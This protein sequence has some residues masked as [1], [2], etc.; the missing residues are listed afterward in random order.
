[1]GMNTESRISPPHPAGS[2]ASACIVKR[3]GGSGPSGFP[4]PFSVLILGIQP[5]DFACPACYDP[6]GFCT[7]GLCTIN[8]GASYLPWG[9]FQHSSISPPLRIEPA[10]SFVK[11][12]SE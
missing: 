11:G 6:G 4:C 10:S 7:V 1:M 8:A 3:H 2:E 5:L 12:G 9:S